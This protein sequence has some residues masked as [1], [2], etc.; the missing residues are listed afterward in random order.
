VANYEQ[1]RPVTDGFFTK[2]KEDKDAGS[3]E[4]ETLKGSSIPLRY[5]EGRD[6]INFDRVRRDQRRAKSEFIQFLIRS[7]K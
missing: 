4:A 6:R 1:V 7:L 5:R 3:D 2:S